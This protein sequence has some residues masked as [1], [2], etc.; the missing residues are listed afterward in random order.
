MT[1]AI[2]RDSRVPLKY[3]PKA[4]HRVVCAINW[5]ARAKG[6]GIVERLQGIGQNV[7]NYDLDLACVL[8][9]AE[10]KAV[11]G[12]SSRPEETADRSGR[13]YHTGDDE[14][15]AGDLDDEA[16]SIELNGLPDYIQHIVFVT[17]IQSRHTFADVNNPRIRL[18]DGMNNENQLD[19]P[20]GGKTGGGKTA[21]VFARIYRHNSGWMLHFIDEYYDRDKVSDWIPVLKKYLG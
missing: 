10:G 8:Y 1:E 6:P 14:S 18:A 16:I 12:V 19:V 20:L 7:K 11:D 13:I 17:E 21:Y 2:A 15:G 3:T 9:D 5:D 4:R